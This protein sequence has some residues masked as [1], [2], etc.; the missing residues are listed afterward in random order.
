[1]SRRAGFER[2]SV[3]DQ[4]EVVAEEQRHLD[5]FIVAVV[6]V[7]LL[8]VCGQVFAGESKLEEPAGS[9]YVHPSVEIGATP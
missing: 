3:E 7:F 4:A 2:L 8:W 5:W 6:V 9:V 1:M